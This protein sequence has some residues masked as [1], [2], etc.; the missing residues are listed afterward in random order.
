MG[1]AVGQGRAQGMMTQKTAGTDLFNVKHEGPQVEEKLTGKILIPKSYAYIYL[2]DIPER[3]LG[4]KSTAHF[5]H[6]S[7]GKRCLEPARDWLPSP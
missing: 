5:R 4:L 2:R 6:Q 1:R 7:R 3:A